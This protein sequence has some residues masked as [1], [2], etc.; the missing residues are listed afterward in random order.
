M[1]GGITDAAAVRTF[2][3]PFITFTRGP[4]LCSGEGILLF[5]NSFIY[6]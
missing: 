5:K 6:S 1:V 3:H 2:H 4:A